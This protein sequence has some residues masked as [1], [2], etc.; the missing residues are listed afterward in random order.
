[1][2]ASEL[3]PDGHSFAKHDLLAPKHF[4][5]Y[6]YIC[7]SIYANICIYIYIYVYIYIYIYIK[8]THIYIEIYMYMHIYLYTY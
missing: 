8:Y 6:M 4:N 2:C 5:T 7:L 3:E 1:M